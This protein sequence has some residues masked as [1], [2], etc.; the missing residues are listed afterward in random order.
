[1]SD[2]SSPRRQERQEDLLMSFHAIK[3]FEIDWYPGFAIE[4]QVEHLKLQK[5]FLEENLD[6]KQSSLI[7]DFLEPSAFQPLF[8]KPVGRGLSLQQQDSIGSNY[9]DRTYFKI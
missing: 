1:M 6:Q 9:K 3:N 4:H 5:E 8:H 2:R 7:V